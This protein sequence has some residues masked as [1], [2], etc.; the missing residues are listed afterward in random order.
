MPLGLMPVMS[1][2]E[3]ETILAPGDSTLFYSDGLVEAHKPQGE[4][5]GFPRLRRLIAEHDTEQ[6]SLVAFLMEEL[7]SFTGDG[8]EQDG[9]APS[10]RTVCL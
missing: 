2:D 4:R 8:L 10:P 1:Y 7:R 3:K 6:G 5:F 9:F